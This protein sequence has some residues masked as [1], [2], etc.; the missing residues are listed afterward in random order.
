MTEPRIIKKY[1]NRRLY[2]TER[3]CYITV[4]DVRT[5][6][7]DGVEIKVIDAQ[8]EEDITRG[9][10]IQIITEHESG[11]KGAFTTEMLARFIRLSNDA[12]RDVFS[13]YLDQSMRLFLEQ[14]QMLSKQMQEALS[15]K[16]LTGMAKQNLEFWQSLL[17]S[18]AGVPPKTPNGKAGK[19]SK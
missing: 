10:L 5:L 8:T 12:A 18:A 17:K 13:R 7:L 2:D 11:N 16:A 4:D 6:V 1:P 9:I 14:Q 15:G 19:R 3:S